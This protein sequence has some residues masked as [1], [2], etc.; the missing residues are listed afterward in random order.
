[1]SSQISINLI[2]GR[3][4][5]LKHERALK[6]KVQFVT[7]FVLV[8]FL[9]LLVVVLGLS[10]LVNV[11]LKQIKTQA[12][13]ETERIG[14]L[15]F[16]EDEYLILQNKVALLEDIFS[17]NK[18]VLDGLDY[19]TANLPPE[20]TISEISLDNQQMSLS[21]NLEA[22]AYDTLNNFLD[23]AMANIEQDKFSK[24]DFEKISRND[25]GKYSSTVTM[26]YK[27]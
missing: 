9:G 22:P 14:Q 19:V 16:L 13:K 23:F 21:F 10:T 18:D 8:C 17:V 11:R 2:S 5:E 15:A 12:S 27:S 25:E 26:I 1:M 3:A 24:I 20:I 6:A 4:F 7:A